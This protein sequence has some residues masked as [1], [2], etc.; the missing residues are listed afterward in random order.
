MS[1][2]H[3]RIILSDEKARKQ[4]LTDL[5][6]N[7]LVE[8]S[9]GSGKTSSLVGR[10]VAL[11]QSGTYS[12]E[13]IVAITFTRKAAIEMKERFQEKMESVLMQCKDIRGKELLRKALAD[14]E[15][16]YIGTIHSFCARL[17]REFPIEAGLDPAFQEM[18]EIDNVL[19]MEK[20]WEN[21]LGNLKVTDSEILKNL[22]YS[23]IEIKDLKGCYKQVCLYPDTRI[24]YKISANPNLSKTWKKMVSFCEEADE[25][26][27]KPETEKGYDKIQ[28]AIQQ[29]LRL[30]D[31]SAFIEK[32]YNKISLLEN[33]DRNFSSS[34]T[35]TLNRWQSKEV[36]KHYKETVLPELRDKYIQPALREWR[37]YCYYHVFQFIKP[38][39]EHYHNFR[40]KHSMV[41]F[42]DLLIK[43]AK[44]LKEYPHV[45]KYFQQKYKT[46]LVDEFQDTDPIQ[47]EI[48]F[49]LTGS[50][51]NEKHWQQLV[52][53]QG[54]L[55][56]VGDP[57]QSIY[58]FR[59]ADIAV[60]NQVKSLI[61]KSFGKVIQLNSNFRS[62]KSISDYLNPVFSDLFSSQAGDFQA[63][64]SPMNAVREDKEGILSGIKQLV[65]SKERL[66]EKTIE[67][68]AQAIAKIIK[69]WTNKKY[70]INRKKEELN[71][72]KNPEIDYSDFM[73]LVRYKKGIDIYARILNDYDIPVT[74]S[75][76]AAINQS[77]G[78]RELL[79]LLR[80]L[81]DP[82]NQVLLIAVLRG[83]FYGF[84]DDELYQFKESGGVFDIFTQ[85]PGT[86]QENLKE[87]F[88][89]VF[90]QLKKYYCWSRELLPV[91]AL[92]KIVN[93]SGLQLAAS[94]ETE[95]VIQDNELYFLLQ[96]LRKLEM[97]RF[98]TFSG[99]VEEIERL[100]DSA[101]EE[102][103][104]LKAESNTV[105]IMNLHK[106]KGLEAPIVFLAIPF[107]NRKHEPDC[108][109]QRRTKEPSGYFIV[110]KSNDY[111]SGKIIAQP[112]K[113]EDYCQTEEMYLQ[114]EETRLLYVAATRAKNLLI[115]SSL[116]RQKAQ[117]KN[118][119]WS[120]LLTNSTED[121]IL[122]IPDIPEEKEKK[123][124][125]E[126]LTTDYE[127]CNTEITDKY[128]RLLVAD[129]IEK[130]PSALKNTHSKQAYE[131]PKK[132]IGG[133]DWGNAVHETLEYFLNEQPSDKIL[134]SFIIYV[135]EKNSIAIERK[136]ELFKLIQVFQKSDLYSRITKSEKVLTEVPFNFNITAEESLYKHLIKDIDTRV[137]ELSPILL[138]GIID[139]VF[140][141]P[142]GWI[143]VDYKTDCPEYEKDYEYLEKTYQNQINL[144]AYVWEKL[145]GEKVKDKIIYFTSKQR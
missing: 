128:Q 23:G 19:F 127:K 113:W 138:N 105:R 33:F 67:N 44:L 99:M 48:I 124:K 53:R 52:P 65:I 57:Q 69:D 47:A 142:T 7:F 38:A 16:C 80:L 110:K 11:V 72:G 9:A 145:S 106:A 6:H 24:S 13:Q 40:D 108:H 25:Y 136:E 133:T 60:Y 102:E 107:N 10:M 92:E 35:I 77:Q 141:E 12:I 32:D 114:S 63:K 61:K 55:F 2:D 125:I 82:E 50:D 94:L 39:V 73:I 4:I 20:A 96:Y 93:C 51:I 36:A 68:D 3:N 62:L 118:I 139:L 70:K 74:V 100:W 15:Q 126:Y 103:F 83:I 31:Y 115:I 76:A 119:P 18:D 140:K 28:E 101:V 116:G 137:K 37:E 21:H 135:L 75:G 71:L 117:N 86:V 132:D 89:F 8:A 81:R 14:I 85:I 129:Y 30:K 22:E 84:S 98:Y 42:Q 130:T 66:K 27:P 122:D 134:L 121:M 5:R 41:N 95:A 54:S 120:P 143:I 34:S 17:L 88:R 59:R 29:V 112:P 111:G 104:D 26:I 49:Y 87:R 97:E 64:Y 43:V 56:I 109:I 91:L 79:K 131:P 1:K 45:R 46:L 123:T 58:H 78:I 144:Y 90:E